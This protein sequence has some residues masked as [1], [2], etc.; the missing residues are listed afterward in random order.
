MLRQQ[1]FSPSGLMA[2]PCFLSQHTLTLPRIILDQRLVLLDQKILKTFGIQNSGLNGTTLLV[3]MHSPMCVEK[4]LNT[5][6][7]VQ[8]HSLPIKAG[9]SFIL[10]FKIT[11]TN[12]IAFLVLK[13]SCS[14]VMIQ[15]RFLRKQN[16]LL[17][18]PKNPMNDMVSSQTSSSLL[19]LA[20]KTTRF[21]FI[22]V[23]RTRCALWRN[24]RFQIYFRAW[25]LT[26][27]QHL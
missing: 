12:I 3:I 1:H 2:K 11:T 26:S 20:S 17:L 14:I 8:L 23:E 18:F 15:K 19:A 6:K 4:I 16:F 25:T 24:F 27:A 5:W 21:R 22:M 9:F 10:I 7:S 13:H